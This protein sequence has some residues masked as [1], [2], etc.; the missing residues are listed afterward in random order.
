MLWQQ[1]PCVSLA[2]SGIPYPSHPPPPHPQCHTAQKGCLCAS[3]AKDNF[4]QALY[5]TTSCSYLAQTSLPAQPLGSSLLWIHPTPAPRSH[6]P[7]FYSALQRPPGTQLPAS[8][9]KHHPPSILPGFFSQWR[10]DQ[11]KRRAGLVFKAKLPSVLSEQTTICTTLFKSSA[12]LSLPVRHPHQG[13]R[14]SC[15]Q[16]S[17]PQPGRVWSWEGWGQCGHGCCR[18]Q[19]GGGCGMQTCPVSLLFPGNS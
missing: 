15:C 14:C 11:S 2:S 4:H 9:T 10:G 18:P 19:P 8:L 12:L 7:H 16:R 1:R 3:C 17:Q 6:C 5:P 13:Q